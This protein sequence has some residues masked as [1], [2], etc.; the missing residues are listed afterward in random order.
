MTEMQHLVKQLKEKEQHLIIAKDKA[1]E[2]DRLKTAFLENLSHELR[3]PLTGIVSYSELLIAEDFT[4][5]EK[6]DFLQTIQQNNDNLLQFV[7]DIITLSKLERGMMTSHTQKHRIS[8][9]LNSIKQE[10]QQFITNIHS[11]VDFRFDF[12]TE[13][14]GEEAEIDLTLLIKIIK[15]IVD[16]AF[17]FTTKGEIVLGTFSCE[18]EW[19]IY[20]EDSGIGIPHEKLPLIFNKFFKYS[21]DPRLIYRGVGMGLSIAGELVH[22][23]NGKIQVHSEPGKGSKFIISF[24]HY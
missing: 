1:E 7:E 15:H 24:K 4:K 8:F 20:I 2:G 12:S 14:K 10:I 21:E 23:L 19:G 9:V 22:L 13:I 5:E 16:N 3:T 18:Q 6:S 17:K 11:D